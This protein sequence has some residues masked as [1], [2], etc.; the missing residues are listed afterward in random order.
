MH[1]AWRVEFRIG[2][3]M[4]IDPTQRK[5]RGGDVIMQNLRERI[6]NLLEI[7]DWWPPQPVTPF[8]E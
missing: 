2:E 4:V 7:E 6:L 1:P 3:A 8:E 5:S